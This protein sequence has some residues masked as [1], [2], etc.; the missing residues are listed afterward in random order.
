[1]TE[2]TAPSRR[3]LGDQFEQEIAELYTAMGYEVSRHVPVSGQEVDIL[4]TRR[5]PGGGPY[6]VIV[7][8]K[9]KGGNARAGN[10]DVQAIA[11]AFNIAKATNRASACTVVTTN[12]FTLAAQEAAKAVGIHLATKRQLIKGLIDFSPFLQELKVRYLEEFGEG[13]D[14]WYIDTRGRQGDRKIESLDGFVDDWLARDTKAPLALLGGY[15]TGK[16]SFCR[17]YA[18]RIADRPESPIPIILPLRDFR[19]QMRIESLVRD[20]L[21]EQC[22]APS[23]RFDTFWRMYCEG[24]LLIF[25]DGFDEM[26][27]RVD[28]TVLEANLTEI[29]KFARVIGNVILTCRPEF[30]I[31]RRE[32][33]LAW[34][35]HDDPLSE[36]MAIYKPVE[37]EL[38]MPEQVSRY[39]E[40][41][42]RS[43]KPS[44]PHP[45]KYY[46]ERIQRLPELSD[47]SIRAVHLDLIVR[48]L[49]SMIDKGVPITRPNLYHTYIQRELRRETVRNKRLRVVSDED[50]LALMR[51][52][53]AEQFLKSSDELDFEAASRVV[54]EKLAPP[55]SEVES[56]TRDFLNRSFLHRTG[57]TYR[58]AHK[59]LGEYLFATE[60]YE[61]LRQGDLGF[62]TKTKYSSAVAGMVLELFGG[63]DAFDDMLAALQVDPYRP[64]TDSSEL[65][66]ASFAATSLIDHV[67]GIMF[68]QRRESSDAR[69]SDAVWQRFAMLA[70]E[71]AN[72]LG[73][74]RLSGE[75]VLAREDHSEET[76]TRAS[77]TWQM[78]LTRLDEL[79][80]FRLNR[81]TLELEYVLRRAKVDLMHLVQTAVACIPEEKVQVRGRCRLYY[82]DEN[83]LSSIFEN[84]A[85]N[86]R[87][88][89]EE[90]GQLVVD[91]FDDEEA[92]GVRIVFANTGPEIPAEIIDRIFEFGFTTRPDGHGI[93]L[94]VVK[95]LVELHKG[96]IEVRSNSRETAFEVFLPRI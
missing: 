73:A 79:Q 76:M 91:V 86:A 89:I 6:S 77:K 31:T 56:V 41:R 63:L 52:V 75:L 61:R 57:D 26:A 60:V 1:M 81:L 78:V 30:F 50:R 94:A 33:T 54:M 49:P 14:S 3:Q 15:G 36:R 53:A 71:L 32:E 34:H 87:Y 88:A 39:V 45:S 21:D 17:H 16:T 24:L 90:H 96:T 10:E 19:K 66:S 65:P 2:S 85:L 5:I 69:E 22:D 84:I 82:G 47:M 20:F 44:P 70:H 9:Y 40:K 64:I 92:G 37:I 51:A 67:Q 35:P 12:G 58:F 18:V 29:E 93:G 27:I 46:I 42:V 28:A 4:A 48:I 95:D 68:L 25:L 80:R 83:H 7:E 38:W 62:L 55:K 13:E 8:C 59:S 72:V 43:M 74:M 11:G 23:P